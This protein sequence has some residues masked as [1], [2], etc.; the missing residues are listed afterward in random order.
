VESGLVFDRGDGDKVHPDSVSKAFGR[1][2]QAAGVRQ[3]RFHDLRHT[4]ASIM[5]LSGTNPKVVSE[6][7]GHATVG[8]TLDRYSHLL[9]GLQEEA[10]ER[11]GAL[12]YG[13]G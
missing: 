11:T 13:G 8:F 10:A 6:R 9:P 7:L 5:L 4:S 3:I 2:A 1:L 12:I